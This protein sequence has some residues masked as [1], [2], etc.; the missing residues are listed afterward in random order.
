MVK[1]EEG[2]YLSMSPNDLVRAANHDADDVHISFF[3]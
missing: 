2:I 3:V 1:D